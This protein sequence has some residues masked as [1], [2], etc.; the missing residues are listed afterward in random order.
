MIGGKVLERHLGESELAD[1]VC[2]LGR[3]MAAD[4]AGK[5]PLFVG[6]L[7]GAAIFFSD[8]V[9]ACDFPLEMAFM[10]VS[11][12]Q[13]TESSGTVSV[14]FDGT[15]SVQ[16]RTVVVVDDVLD[17]GTTMAFLR[18]Y[19][20][21]KGAAEVRTAAMFLKPDV[22]R[23]DFTPEYVGMEIGKAFIVG[24]GL[25]YEGEGRHWK[26]IYRMIPEEMER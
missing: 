16:G 25:D 7:K 13:G 1:C 21:E 26:E 8:L 19:F 22:F 23:G 14:V 15:P 9:R 18:R 24:Y 17:T 6:I 3:E 2:R 12:Y 11:S 20:Q 5:K 10:Q 4:L